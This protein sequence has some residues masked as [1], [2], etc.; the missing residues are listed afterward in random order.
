MLPSLHIRLTNF[1]RWMKGKRLDFF[2]VSHPPNIYYLTGFTGSSGELVLGQEWGVL[3]TD[4]RYKTQARAEVR[5]ASVLIHKG[6][7][8]E[9]VGGVLDGRRAGTLGFEA[10][11]T[12]VLGV[13]QL[14]RST[15]RSIR[16]RGHTG[17]VEALRAI[18]DAEEISRLRAA[19]SLIGRVFEKVLPLVRPG[20]SELELAAEIEYQI[21]GLGAEGASFETIVASGRR[22]A[23]PH[24]RPTSKLLRKNELVV[25]DLGAIL[26]HYCSDLTRT[27]Y[28]G[29]APG[30]VRSIY[31]AVREA[32]AEALAN[33][34]PATPCA[35]VDQATRR[36]LQ[37]HRLDRYFVHSLGHGLG[38]EIHEEPRLAA[39]IKSRLQA[40]HVVTVE[41]GVYI[42]G[43]GGIR[44]E[45]DVLV[46][47]DG[48]EVLTRAP[49]E[50][51]E[52]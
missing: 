23:Q 16:L 52:L 2:L 51:L 26:R 11:H 49:R 6:P 38:L 10:E 18:K 29:R 42:P 32:Q 40:G 20:R 14:R 19:A 48:A 9:A 25:L 15:G 4:G 8:L 36:V 45:D 24:A 22:S 1:R 33:I 21:R 44:I 31:G 39:G 34:R 50:F 17:A 3:I 7:P 5:G 30:R 41:P 27:V 47:R 12:S 37:R 13:R 43:F 46:T 28:L 35:E